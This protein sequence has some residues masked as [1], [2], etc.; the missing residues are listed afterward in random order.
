MFKWTR[1][2][3]RDLNKIYKDRTKVILIHQELW[4]YQYHTTNAKEGHDNVK[5]FSSQQ[6]SYNCH[7]ETCTMSAYRAKSREACKLFRI[8]DPLPNFIQMPD[9]TIVC[10]WYQYWTLFPCNCRSS[11]NH[12]SPHDSGANSFI[13]LISFELLHIFLSPLSIYTQRFSCCFLGQR[14]VSLVL[15]VSLKV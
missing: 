3:N 4:N 11:Q 6:P 10:K 12:F 5:N 9:K 8:N 15:Q 7:I 2:V 14:F 13:K 1:H